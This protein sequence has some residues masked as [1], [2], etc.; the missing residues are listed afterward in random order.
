[1]FSYLA[2]VLKLI[3]EYTNIYIFFL[4]IR[5]EIIGLNRNIFFYR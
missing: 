5:K 4:N 2:V 3:K 1:M